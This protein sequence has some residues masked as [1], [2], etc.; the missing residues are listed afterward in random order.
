MAYHSI[1]SY[2]KHEA[3]PFVEE[4]IKGLKVKRKNVIVGN[5]QHL[6]VGK[7]TG[8]IEGQVAFMKYVEVESD[9]FVKIFIAELQSLFNL[10]NSSIKVFGYILSITKPNDDR[11]IFSMKKCREYTGYKSDVPIFNGLASLLENGFIARTD[12]PSIYFINPLVFFNGDRILFV[13]QYVKRRQSALQ[14][15]PSN[16]QETEYNETETSSN[17]EG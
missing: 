9:K 10:S 15:F 17:S 1:K 4:T 16:E 12:S 11:V 8:E 6:I 5:P 3:N 13:K 14:L 2:E 7:N